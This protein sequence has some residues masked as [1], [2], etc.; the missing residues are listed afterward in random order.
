MRVRGCGW[1]SSERI[2]GRRAR[3]KRLAERAAEG[4]AANGPDT[5]RATGS[6]PRGGRQE[7]PSPGWA[8]GNSVPGAGDR[9]RRPRAFFSTPCLITS[10]AS[11]QRVGY[12]SLGGGCLFCFN[13]SVRSMSFRFLHASFSPFRCP[14]WVSLSPDSGDT[15]LGVNEQNAT[16]SLPRG[17]G[18]QPVPPRGSR[19]G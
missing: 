9:K 15:V 8:T 11:F 17:V 3:R 19:A 6:G 4:P 5:G 7:T 2:A 10:S 14:G 12:F 13:H 16:L 1:C 18:G